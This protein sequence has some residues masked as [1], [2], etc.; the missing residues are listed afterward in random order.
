MGPKLIHCN[1]FNYKTERDI[2]YH[3]LFTFDQLKL[4]PETT[5][6]ILYGQMPQVSPVYHL[7]KK[8]IKLTSFAEVGYNLPVQLYLQP[9]SGALF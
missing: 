5:E 3:V 9:A 4:S 2:L 7:F 1:I 6:L 8:Y